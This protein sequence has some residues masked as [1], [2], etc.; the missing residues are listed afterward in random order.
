MHDGCRV[1]QLEKASLTGELLVL[2]AFEARSCSQEDCA[3][4][5]TEG[6]AAAQG[7]KELA[8]AMFK[9]GSLDV[10]RE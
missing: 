4:G 9:N 2:P 7:P 6:L 10:F 5:L 3:D 8:I 1:K